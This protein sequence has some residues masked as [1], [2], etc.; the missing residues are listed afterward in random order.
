MSK[1][2]RI[3]KKRG[4]GWAAVGYSLRMARQAG[5]IKFTKALRRSNV[6]KTCALGM[7]G[8]KNELGHGFQVC[9]KAMQA[10]AQDLRPA[11]PPEF[12]K[13]HSIEQLKAYSGRD[14]ESLGRLSHP[15]FRGADSTHFEVIS[16]EEAY[17]KVFEQFRSVDHSRSF[18]YTSGRSSNEAAFLIQLLARQ[19]GT[20]NIN[21]CSYY[22]HQASGVGLKQTFGSGT[23]TVMLEDVEKSDLVVLIGCNPS[24]NHP[25]FMTFLMNLRS[26]GGNVL[27]V[28][29]FVELGLE[30]FGVPSK[31]GSL[32]FTTEIA[33]E[34]YQPHCGGD[35]SF[36]KA[37]CV[38]LWRDGKAN[39]K[40]LE[41]NCN[42]YQEWVNDLESQDIDSL[43]VKSGLSQGELNSFVDYL[44]NAKSIIF[45]WAMG[46][47]HQIHGVESVRTLA[48]LALMLGQV[49]NPG[50]GLLPLRGHSNVQGVGTNGVVP[51]LSQ[52]M[53]DALAQHLNLVVPKESG[54]DTHSSME[55]ASQGKIDFAVLLGGNLYGA[56][57]DLQWASDALNQISFTLQIST[58]LN[59]GHLMGQGKTSL[60][61]PVRT[62][63]E[64]KQITTQ[65]S[66]FNYVR[67]SS[68]GAKAPIENLPSE[69]EIITLI[70]KELYNTN[71]VPWDQFSDHTIIR[72]F[73][74]KTVPGMR[75][76]SEIVE[77][78]FT[79]PGRIYH[80]PKFSTEDGKA[81]LA[82][83][84]SIDAT[85]EQQHYNL[86]SFRSEGQFNTIVYDEEDIYRGVSHRNVV[87]IHEEDG[88]SL[89]I[90]DGDMVKLVSEVGSLEVEAVFSRIRP[91]NVAMFY[92][93]ANAI[94]PANIDP[95]SKTPSFKRC[96]VKISK[97]S[98]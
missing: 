85:P 56:N 71:P 76:V 25:R 12:W 33:S 72:D 97:I 4:G 54:F 36:L 51:K 74:S 34:Y 55:A 22:C 43:L 89:G 29:P 81:N 8:M 14:L 46:I 79:I 50:S 35:L 28:N 61:L 20:N 5:P 94:I 75:E 86:T 53:I 39:K 96:Q 6:C 16:W 17:Q 40:F 63:D 91:K 57:P 92:P 58:T 2:K 7:K 66:M 80:S 62:R 11:I 10:I 59:Q 77:K 27:V 41:E 26:R 95:Q 70:G 48:N 38:K 52:N 44:V 83:V 82:I 90:E 68:G 30:R 65:E 69:V 98:S 67:Y 42:N 1:S 31:I 37:V 3:R 18:F 87:F 9:K 93:E 19:Y 73:I 88:K 15:L 21:N 45:S 78:E 64:E 24:S 32:L 13:Q 47:T 49:G 23:S 84:E 60:I